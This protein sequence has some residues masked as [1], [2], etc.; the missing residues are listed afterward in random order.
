VGMSHVIVM[1]I[2]YSCK[3]LATMMSPNSEH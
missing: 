1:G 2:T 3:M